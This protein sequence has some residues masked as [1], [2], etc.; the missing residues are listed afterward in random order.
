MAPKPERRRRSSEVERA[1][2]IAVRT[3]HLGAVVLLGAA[4]LGAPVASGTAG[5]VTLASGVVLAAL[6]L[7]AGRLRLDELAG[8]VLLAKLAVVAWIAL[9]AASPVAVHVGFW[10]L[11]VV[12]SI[13][14]H[15]PKALRHWRPGRAAASK[16]GRPG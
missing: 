9:G 3:V 11:L 5:L 13:S 4:L 16:A 2:A 12:S 14:A 10:A 7:I 8:A 6:D 1:L 15:A